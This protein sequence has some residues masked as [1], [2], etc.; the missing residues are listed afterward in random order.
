MHFDLEDLH[1]SQ[2]FNSAPAGTGT[3]RVEVS[4]IVGDL[5]TQHAVPKSFEAYTNE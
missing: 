5:G 4:F 1:A 3:T 2:D